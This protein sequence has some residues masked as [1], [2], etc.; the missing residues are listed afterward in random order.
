MSRK[1]RFLTALGRTIIQMLY[2]VGGIACVALVV[3]VMMSFEYGLACIIGALAIG[4]WTKFNYEDITFENITTDRM[5]DYHRASK[6]AVEK[7]EPPPPPP[8]RIV[9]VGR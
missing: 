8:A 2:V 5:N 1:D 9:H 4:V 3:K 6:E 7:G